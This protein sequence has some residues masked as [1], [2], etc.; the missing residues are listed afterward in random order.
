VPAACRTHLTPIGFIALM[1]VNCTSYGHAASKEVQ[2]NHHEACGEL[3][4]DD[5]PAMYT[6]DNVHF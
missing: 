3:F 2:I 1:T 4:Y 5:N 6:T